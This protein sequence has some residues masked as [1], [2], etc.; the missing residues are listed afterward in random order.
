MQHGSDQLACPLNLGHSE[1]QVHLLALSLSADQA[2]YSKDR[3]V[4]RQIW[5]GDI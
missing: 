4:L 2:C 1:G 5:L 3:D